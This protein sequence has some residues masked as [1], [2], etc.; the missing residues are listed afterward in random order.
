MFIEN[1]SRRALVCGVISLSIG[2][3][4][5]A[6]QHDST[7][8]QQ[9]ARE[10]A[11]R[12]QAL[13]A[14]ES[15]LAAKEAELKAAA[16][17]QQAAMASEITAPPDSMTSELLPPDAKPGECY[18]RVWVAPTY[19]T[20]T[21]QVVAKEAS[22]QVETIPARYETV[23]EE[24]LVAEA[25]SELR[26]IPA[27]YDTV[28]EQKLVKAAS[29]TWR[30]EP[31][32]SAPPVSQAILDSAVAGG[33]DLDGASPGQCFHEHY[34]PAQ[35]ETVNEQV[36]VAEAYDVI[37]TSEA[38][39]RWI[40][41]QVLVR[42]ASS[43]LETVDA[44]FETVTEQVV[45]VPAHTIWKKGT[46]PI[47]KIDEATGEIMCLV[48]VPATYKTISRRVQV[49]PATSREVEIPA[50]YKT[51]RVR[52]LARDAEEHRRSIEPQYDNVQITKKV[53]DYD[54]VWH[55]IHNT[56]E[57]KTTRTGR[58]ICLVAEPAK[59]ETV[60]RR[61]VTSP[62]RTEK[63]EIPAR[64]ETVTVTKLVEAAREVRTEIPAVYET[65][66]RQELEKEGF[67]EWRTILCETNMTV[68]VI[69]DIQRRLNEAGYNPGPIDGVI[70]RQTIDAVNRFQRDK[71]LP[72][73]R[74]LNIETI[75]AL[76]ISI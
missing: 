43:R 20:L 58:K 34:R 74:Y 2:I 69:S 24:V 33:I 57:P 27:V 66:T 10:L 36:L 65:V 14:R 6:T 19:R 40:E 39:Y 71:S 31:T 75:R 3:S 52:E 11:S 29:Q 60:T 16:D 68:G 76:G 12:A 55:E 59:Y 64:Y 4:G 26:T 73:D 44:V 17:A 7:A 61:V 53:S 72:V 47:Q 23:T 1:F 25:F 45:D 67:M 37:E 41:K 28:S 63:V 42:E 5:C 62:A 13:S 15:A 18:A 9:Q 51:V 22:E 46:G 70:G 30:V 35:Y 38:E 48:E 50:E 54:F 32:V 8:N 49:S 56:S 21:E